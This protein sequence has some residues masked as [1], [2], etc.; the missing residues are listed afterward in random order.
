MFQYAKRLDGVTGSTIRD[1]FSLLSSSTILSFAGGNPAP[2]SF[3][4]SELTRIAGQV[5]SE[6]ASSLLQYGATEGFLPLREAILEH[7]LAPRGIQAEIANILPV[8]GSSQGIDLIAR[9]LLDPG[10]TVLVESPTFLG[11]LQIF[12]IA[13]ANLVP[14]QMDRQG[15]LADDLERKIRQYRPK[16]L[17]TIPTFQNP[18]GRTLP[19]ERRQAV[20]Q[21]CAEHGVLVIEDDPYCDLR[22]SGDP[23]PPIQFFDS[24][25]NIAM[26]NSFSKIIS[27]G[28]RLGYVVAH[29]KLLRKLTIIKQGADTHTANLN[30]AIVNAFL[31]EDLLPAHIDRIKA[32]YRERLSTM[33][34]GIRKFFPA[35]TE[36][37]LPDGGIFAWIKLGANCNTKELLTR[38]IDEAKVAYI[39]GEH[40]FIHPSEGTTC[41]RLNFSSSTPAEILAGM[42]R[43]GNL[44]AAAR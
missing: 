18:T 12:Q 9:A 36:Y 1:I 40:F 14:V 27:P 17:Y 6:N 25:G 3:P 35:D 33:T 13:Q 34:Q 39:P 16:A 8:T 44:I 23:L 41:L 19:L 4:Q 2:E 28:L 20:A 32:C 26:L 21:L 11:A 42:E 30:Q 37:T 24:C 5:L 31:R 43:L 22:Y 38:A 7:M 15:I 29:P 10:D